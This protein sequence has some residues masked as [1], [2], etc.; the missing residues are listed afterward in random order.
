MQRTASRPGQS[1]P[2][3]AFCA[4]PARVPWRSP[5]SLGNAIQHP[6]V[7]VSAIFNIACWFMQLPDL[8]KKLDPAYLL[9]RE[10]HFDFAVADGL[11]VAA[12]GQ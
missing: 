3:Q 4:D 12:F 7:W 2:D 11:W 8:R 1:R 9:I 10:L 6:R 5:T